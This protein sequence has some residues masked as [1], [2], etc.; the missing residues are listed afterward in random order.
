MESGAGTVYQCVYRVRLRDPE[1]AP[2]LLSTLRGA[3]P[4]QF[5]NLL[6]DPEHE[7]VA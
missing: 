1:S 7:E 2:D 6:V 4:I 3:K 5:V